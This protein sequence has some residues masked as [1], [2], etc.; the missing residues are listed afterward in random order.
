LK[1]NKIKIEDSNE[2]IFSGKRT[3]MDNEVKKQ[4]IK[5]YNGL[6]E[7]DNRSIDCYESQGDKKSPFLNIGS[8]SD[9]VVEI[10]NKETESELPIKS[11]HVRKIILEEHLEDI[12]GRKIS[13]RLENPHYF[14]TNKY[15]EKSR[16]SQVRH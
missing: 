13:N 2:I 5:Y 7:F 16:P 8:S 10:F 15:I 14:F 3:M 9:R 6:K 4:Y 1:N 11:K 12:K